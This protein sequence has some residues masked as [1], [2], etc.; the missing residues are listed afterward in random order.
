MT[1]PADVINM[2]GGMDIRLSKIL[3]QT[4]GGKYEN[5]IVSYN[6]DTNG[7]LHIYSDEAFNGSFAIASDE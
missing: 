6:V 5:V 4:P 2:G 1:I 3:R 7:N